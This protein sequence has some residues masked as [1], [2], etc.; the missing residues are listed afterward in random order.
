MAAT[1][2]DFSDLTALFVNTTLTRSQA[3]S[4][5]QILIDSSAAIMTT[6]GVH[7][8][9]FRSIDHSIASGVY[10]NMREHG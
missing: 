2:V 5:T 4:H 8:D 6:Q 10:P 9:Q 7:V 3:A 1:D